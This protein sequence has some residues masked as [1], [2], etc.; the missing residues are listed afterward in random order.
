[1]SLWTAGF[2]WAGFFCFLLLRSLKKNRPFFLWTVLLLI[3]QLFRLIIQIL[4]TGL[5]EAIQPVDFVIEFA[6][7]LAGSSV[8]ILFLAV[9]KREKTP[10]RRNL[11][12][13][14]TLLA[15]TTYSFFWVGSYD[16]HY[17]AE[18]LN[19]GSVNLFTF[20]LWTIGGF[21]TIHVYRK[22]AGKPFVQRISMIWIL[23]LIILF[24]VEYIGYSL[25][26][27]HE[28]SKI[29]SKPLLF[30]LIHGTPVLHLFYLISPFITIPL[31]ILYKEITVRCLSSEKID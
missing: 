27:V 17:N 24:I 5:N 1:M 13:V 31:Y 19:T 20:I 30:G 6:A 25:F 2:L 29:N 15:S 12:R 26:G 10:D 28:N 3:F 23:Y 7:G 22:F 4:I 16:Y 9:A 14:L 11:Q 21:T 18:I 8:A